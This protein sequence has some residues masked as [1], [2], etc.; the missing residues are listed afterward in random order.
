MANRIFGS[1]EKEVMAVFTK[2]E[3]R[4]FGEKKVCGL[5][6]KE[7][8]SACMSLIHF[9]EESGAGWQD[10]WFHHWVIGENCLREWLTV[11][12]WMPD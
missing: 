1:S 7:G 11:K 12:G 2:G 10:R 6:G 5:C 9:K 8:C 4:C 3:H